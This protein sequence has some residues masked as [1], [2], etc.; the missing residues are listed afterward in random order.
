MIKII[1][2]VLMGMAAG[3]F[4][5]WFAYEMG[6]KEERAKIVGWLR[7]FRGEIGMAL[8]QMIKAGEHLK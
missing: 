8:A 7:A 1:I 2:A 3:G 5:G 6:V 4:I